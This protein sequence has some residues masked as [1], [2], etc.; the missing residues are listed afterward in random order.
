MV[1]HSWVD[2]FFCGFSQRK[3]HKCVLGICFLYS[4]DDVTGFKVFLLGEFKKKKVSLCFMLNYNQINIE[5]FLDAYTQMC[6]SSK[7]NCNVRIYCFAQWI[8]SL[9][10]IFVWKRIAQ[11]LIG[12]GFWVFLLN[13]FFQSPSWWTTTLLIRNHG[14]CVRCNFN[15]KLSCFKWLTFYSLLSSGLS[16]QLLLCT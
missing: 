9:N 10:E 15:I 3:K 11:T 16:C 4:A 12:R 6:L 5:K 13:F 8:Q 1:L 2:T 14:V 7:L